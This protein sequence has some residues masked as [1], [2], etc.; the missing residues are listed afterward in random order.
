MSA[1][2]TSSPPLA[3]VKPT[4]R[5]A[6]SDAVRSDLGKD[7]VEIARIA[8]LELMEWQA[9]FLRDSLMHRETDPIEMGRHRG[10]VRRPEAEREG[11]D[12]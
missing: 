4:V 9:D 3:N 6:P 2:Q 8:G 1:L 7:A 10:G 12:P 5:H 11:L